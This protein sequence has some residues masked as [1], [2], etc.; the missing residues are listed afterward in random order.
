MQVTVPVVNRKLMSELYC[1]SLKRGDECRVAFGR[2]V[3]DA[4]AGTILFL[5]PGQAFTPMEAAAGAP[6]SEDGWTLVFHPDLL[7]ASELATRIREYGFFRYSSEEALHLNE[8][9]QAKLT[10]L[11]RGLEGEAAVAADAFSNEVLVGY[12]ELLLGYCRRF[13]ARQFQ[14]RASVHGGVLSRLQRHLD[15]YLGSARPRDEGLPTVAACARSLGYSSDYLSDLLR[16]ETGEGGR[17]HI[18]RALI[19]AAKRRLAASR[20]NVSEIA[21]GLGFEQPQHFSKLFKQK[22][23]SSPRQWREAAL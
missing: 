18:H 12:L 6:H 8:D 11:V 17:D 16:Q 19:E 14:T 21:Y 10:A 5:A 4:Q 2:Q 1:V 7:H 22:T 13:Y 9:E 3:H 23:G 20:D 15:E